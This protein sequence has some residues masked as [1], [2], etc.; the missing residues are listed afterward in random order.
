MRPGLRLALETDSDIELIRQK[1]YEWGGKLV[2]FEQRGELEKFSIISPNGNKNENVLQ[3]VHITVQKVDSDESLFIYSGSGCRVVIEVALIDKGSYH[4][5]GKKEIP[6]IFNLRPIPLIDKLLNDGVWYRNQMLVDGSPN[7]IHFDDVD[8]AWE[9]ILEASDRIPQVIIGWGGNGDL[10]S[11]DSR[12][13]SKILAGIANVHVPSSRA[14]MKALNDKMGQ[15]KIPNG[16]VRLLKSDPRYESKQPL[17]SKDKILQGVNGRHF[18]IDIFIRTANLTLKGPNLSM[19]SEFKSRVIDVKKPPILEQSEITKI[20]DFKENLDD[21]I[22]DEITKVIDHLVAENTILET[23][24]NH[25][26]EEIDS[27]TNENDELLFKIQN[28]ITDNS[29]IEEEQKGFNQRMN[30]LM[31][32]L[33]IIN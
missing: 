16:G 27:L 1:I 2:E 25:L 14:T 19:L 17:Y 32:N 10:P 12:I 28:N 33:K 29:S 11:T 26:R 20:D 18:E 9:Q 22:F 5:D 15:V 21:D 6:S 13:L 31:N 8:E 23:E 7:P 24:N 4:G 3:F 30:R